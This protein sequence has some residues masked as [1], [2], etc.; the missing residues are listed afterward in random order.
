MDGRAS[1]AEAQ[2]ERSCAD[3]SASR[4]DLTRVKVFKITENSAGY[5]VRASGTLRNGESARL[6]CL[7]SPNG[8]IRDVTIEHH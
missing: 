3:A 8:S 5:T 1:G 4:Y 6:V 7:T 2:A